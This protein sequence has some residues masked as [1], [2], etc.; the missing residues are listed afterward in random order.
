[1]MEMKHVIVT[2]MQGRAC[3]VHV[4]VLQYAVHTTRDNS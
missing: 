1:M 4:R 3:E 2:V